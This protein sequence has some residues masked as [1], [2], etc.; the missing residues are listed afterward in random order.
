MKT[1]TES[2]LVHEII[3]NCTA[4]TLSVEVLLIK[5]PAPSRAVSNVGNKFNQSTK[6][7]GESERWK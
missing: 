1:V 2:I 5:Y 7:G 4:S 3:C 6:R